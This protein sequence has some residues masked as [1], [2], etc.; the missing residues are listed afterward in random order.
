MLTYADVC[1]ADVASLESFSAFVAALE[2]SE[3]FS[4]A[5]VAN[6]KEAECLEFR[7]VSAAAPHQMSGAEIDALSDELEQDLT[8]RYGKV[9]TAWSDTLIAPWGGD[10]EGGW[11]EEALQA[12][13]DTEAAMSAAVALIETAE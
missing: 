13:T 4:A 9:G 5:T 10:E 2:S 6:R 7:Q 12:E 8:Q 1:S 3:T 11:E